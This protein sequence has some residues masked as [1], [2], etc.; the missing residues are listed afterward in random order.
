[1]LIRLAYSFW[2]S[3]CGQVVLAGEE[4]GIR[5]LTLTD[6]GG[7]RAALAALRRLF[8]AAE[9]RADGTVLKAAVQELEEYFA[10]RRR[11]FTVPLAPM[12]TAFQQRVWQELRAIPFGEVRSYGE[13]ARRLG[14]PTAARAVGGA[15]GRNP[16]ALFIP[17]HRVIR[18]DGSLGGFGCG[19]ARKQ[20][21]LQHEGVR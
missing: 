5:F 11:A 18:S 2:E 8:P 14:Q 21:L 13:L 12:G 1:M 4:V 17:C 19:L 15:C 3:P 6:P 7:K 9:W 20:W 16:I 10:G